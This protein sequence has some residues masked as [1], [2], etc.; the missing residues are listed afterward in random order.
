MY[1]VD[2]TEEY[3]ELSGQL[4]QKLRQ[5]TLVSLASKAKVCRSLRDKY[6]LDQYDCALGSHL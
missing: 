3:I 4:V 6:T 2:N 5:L 1:Y